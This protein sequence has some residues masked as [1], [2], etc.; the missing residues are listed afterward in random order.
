M[1][2]AGSESSGGSRKSVRGWRFLAEGGG[3]S[4]KTRF[5]AESRHYNLFFSFL[6][7]KNAK[8]DTARG[9]GR[10]IAVLLDPPVSERPVISI[11]TI[12]EML[13]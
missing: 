12:F 4:Q 10:R 1:I 3:Y 11:I 6:L 5:K 13:T 2:R 7:W 8:N 9:G